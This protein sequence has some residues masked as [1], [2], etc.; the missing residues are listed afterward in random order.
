MKTEFLVPVFSFGLDLL[1]ELFKKLL[2][3]WGSRR[4]G[5]EFPLGTC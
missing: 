5:L 1:L 3:R 2:E 4:P